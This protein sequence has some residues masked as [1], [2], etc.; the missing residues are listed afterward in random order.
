M[1]N[2]KKLLSKISKHKPVICS[3]DFPYF[4]SFK[5][6]SKTRSLP[7]SLR[8]FYYQLQNEELTYDELMGKCELVT[9]NINNK[10]VT[11][12]KMFTHDQNKR[13]A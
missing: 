6:I 9:I 1:K 13:S 8:D 11:N 12:I 5:P 4:N 7:L 10:D 2:K 3:T